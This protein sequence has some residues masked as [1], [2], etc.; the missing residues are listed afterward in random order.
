MSN[1]N[2]RNRQRNYLKRWLS[3]TR[4]LNAQLRA[5]LRGQFGRY[6]RDEFLNHPYS[7]FL[8]APR[9]V[10]TGFQYPY[11]REDVQSRQDQIQG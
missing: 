1:K 9:F 5:A 6:L 8:M 2:Q 4:A 11:W 3:P 10:G 7:D